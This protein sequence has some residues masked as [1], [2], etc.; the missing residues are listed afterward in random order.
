MQ[1][2]RGTVTP[3]GGEGG[4]DVDDLG[5]KP[6]TE[7]GEVQK[8][9]QYEKDKSEVV[10]SAMKA[11]VVK[12]H[13]AVLATNPR[14][15]WSISDDFLRDQVLKLRGGG[16]ENELVGAHGRDEPGNFMNLF[17]IIVRR[18][19]SHEGFD[20]LLCEAIETD[21]DMIPINET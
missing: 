1:A 4:R 11:K 5:L 6:T 10:P 9:E 18:A 20:E 21:C 12:T 8:D 13:E 19:T 17:L 2:F 16:G 15:A 3:Q 14:H 7:R